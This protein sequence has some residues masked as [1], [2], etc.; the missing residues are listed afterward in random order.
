MDATSGQ[1]KKAYEALLARSKKLHTERMTAIGAMEH[2]LSQL[3]APDIVAA[4]RKKLKL[5]EGQRYGIRLPKSL[6]VHLVDD[7]PSVV[8]DELVFE[9]NQEGVQVAAVP[10][11]AVGTRAV[12]HPEALRNKVARGDRTV[13]SLLEAVAKLFEKLYSDLSLATAQ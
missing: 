6:R 8:A 9:F 12:L 10:A 2:V 7:L 11:F 13:D 1:E 5:G 3:Q 4:V